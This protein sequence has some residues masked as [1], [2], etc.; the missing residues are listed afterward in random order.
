MR[1]MNVRALTKRDTLVGQGDAKRDFA[2]FEQFVRGGPAGETIV[3]DWSGVKIATASYLAGTCL[4]L[5][6]R[7]LSGELDK[8]FV[9]FGL[10]ENCTAE[11]KLVLNAEGLVLLV[12]DRANGNKIESAHPLGNLERPYL[13][14]FSETLR[15]RSVSASALHRKPGS[16]N[17]PQIGKTA[18]INRLTNLNRVRLLRRTKVGREFLYEVPF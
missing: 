9:L 14:T 13:E 15:R 11:L 1:F 8:F 12:A 18:W 10:N 16:G 2:L 4:L 5:F 6:K 3:W 17:G 7:T